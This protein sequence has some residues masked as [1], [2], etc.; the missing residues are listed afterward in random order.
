MNPII[1]EFINK[2]ICIWGWGRE[3]QSTYSFINKFLPNANITI[4]DKN[5]I[6]EKSL[7]YISETELIE[8]IDLFDLIIKSPGISLYNFNI[9]K[10]D[11]LTS[12]VELFLKHYKHKTIGVTD[13]R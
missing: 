5:K 4:A 10:S 6:K 12:Q 13:K 3:G 7:K 9:K 1:E 2:N 8:K 11:K